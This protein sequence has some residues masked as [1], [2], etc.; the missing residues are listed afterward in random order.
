M[1]DAE[2]SLTTNAGSL[3]GRVALVTGAG[4]GIGRAIAES[5]AAAGAFVGIHYRESADDARATLDA[6]VQSGGNGMLL[7]ADLM[8]VEQC[9]SVVDQLI[10]ATG[11]L[12][13]LV[14]NAGSPIER[15]C[16]W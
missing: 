8:V 14:N 1:S 9:A 7:Q 13:I 15:A 12:D 5:L 3:A 16:F 6:I 11:R 2:E 10:T 4:V